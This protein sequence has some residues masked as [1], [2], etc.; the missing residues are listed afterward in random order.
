MFIEKGQ[1][2]PNQIISG[3]DKGIYIT[4]VLGMHTANPI[5]GDFSLGVTGLMIE[6]GKL[7][8]PVRGVALAGNIIDMMKK[9]EAVGSDLTFFGGMG[10]PTLLISD[11]TLS[12]N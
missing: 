12:G 1:L 4:E 6:N 10:A 2:S 5:S 11:M 8:Y 7:T 9:I 3:L